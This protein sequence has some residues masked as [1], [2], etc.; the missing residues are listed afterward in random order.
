MSDKGFDVP[1]FDNDWTDMGLT[2]PAKGSS[3]RGNGEGN[4]VTGPVGGRGN[5]LKVPDGYA[6]HAVGDG[7]VGGPK[8]KRESERLDRKVET[9]GVRKREIVRLADSRHGLSLDELMMVLRYLPKGFL[10]LYMALI[11][12]GVGERALGSGSGAG[13]GLAVQDSGRSVAGL[14]QVSSGVVQ[15]RGGAKKGKKPSGGNSSIQ[16]KSQP[17]IDERGRIDR[18]LRTVGRQMAAFMADDVSDVARRVCGGKCK[19]I[20]ESDWLFCPRCGGPMIEQ[21]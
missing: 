20:G 11:D 12:R 9:D 18:K 19:K 15:K 21:D 10:G 17:A 7:G 13:N 4:G 5:S 14:G 16:F 1:V 8:D 2:G 6:S 3:R